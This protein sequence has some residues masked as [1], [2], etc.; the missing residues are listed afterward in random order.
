M[1]YFRC[2]FG[3]HEP[4]I[5]YDYKWDFTKSLEDEITGYTPTLRAGS[6]N[7]APVRTSEGVI[8]TEP[9][10]IIDFSSKGQFPFSGR[11]YEYD[12]SHFEFKGDKT[13][14]I[15]LLC[16]AN[17]EVSGY[18]TVKSAPFIF[19]ANNTIGW[20][21]YG[22]SNIYDSSKTNA[23]NMATSWN[24]IWGSLS[25]NSDE[26]IHCIDGK[27][28]KLVFSDDAYTVSLYLDDT[29]I[30]TMT[31]TSWR[32]SEVTW[33]RGQANNKFMTFGGC[34]SFSQNSGDQCYDMKLT[35]LRIYKTPT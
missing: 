1:A 35:G 32:G 10:Q 34:D 16:F 4:P 24:N 31:G 18:T 3:E 9:T 11:T 15:R 22:F 20:S 29:L 28:V 27:T 13:K 25:G 5:E 2:K 12:I 7:N 26:V 19:R 14:H 30:G 21:M 6:S 23:Y 17:Q 33:S 8:F